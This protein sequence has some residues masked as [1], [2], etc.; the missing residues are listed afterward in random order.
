[1]TGFNYGGS[2]QV[3]GITSKTTDTFTV[4]SSSYI[5]YYLAQGFIA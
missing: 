1:M 2:D 3:L 5:R 4:T